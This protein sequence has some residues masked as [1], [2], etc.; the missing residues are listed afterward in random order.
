MSLAIS[1]HLRQLKY[2]RAYTARIGSS[3]DCPDAQSRCGTDRKASLL[4]FSA[5][6]FPPFRT[7]KLR[8]RKPTCPS[9]GNGNEKLGT[10]K[11]IDYVAFC[12]GKRPNWME[13]GMIY[14][15]SNS[16]IRAKVSYIISTLIGPIDSFRNH[17]RT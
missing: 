16:R 17:G 6:S 11:E 15:N 4:I 1:K 13:R 5:L 8:T 12:G 9:C 2:S 7:V 10:I 3:F 14:A